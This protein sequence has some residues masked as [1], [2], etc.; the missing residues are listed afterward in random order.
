[1]YHTCCYYYYILLLHYYH[2]ITITTTTTATTF[3]NILANYNKNVDFILIH[4]IFLLFLKQYYYEM[5]D[6]YMDPI[7]VAIIACRDN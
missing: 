7:I 6:Y 3:L 2:A 5:I 1:M 4:K